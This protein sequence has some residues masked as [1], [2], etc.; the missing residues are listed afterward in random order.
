MSQIATA[1]PLPRLAGS[2]AK[3]TPPRDLRVVVGAPK[4]HAGLVMLSLVLLTAGLV[5]VLL[6]N[7]SMARGA[8]VLT[9]LEKRSNEL[10]ETQ[11]A[12]RHAID[13]QSAEAELAKRAL[14]LGMV[15]SSTAAFLRLS[16]GQVLGVAEPA[17]EAGRFT[18]VAQ[19]TPAAPAAASAST[20][21]AAKLPEPGTTVTTEGTITR[22]TIIAV[23]ADGVETT[24][25]SV[26]SATG[27]T[28]STTTRTP[29]PAAA[30]VAP[31]ADAASPSPA[32]TAP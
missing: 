7:T 26:D 22:T 32:P 3:V 11:Q 5:A 29:I 8:F 31:A 4:G 20:P 14:D 12:L 27:A 25:T 24:V 6:L 10:S 18:V 13:S 19:A 15:P 16:D 1:R 17:K 23:T 2:R 9:D 21:A 30:A 28:T